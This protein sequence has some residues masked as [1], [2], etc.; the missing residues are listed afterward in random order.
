MPPDS[1]RNHVRFTGILCQIL[2]GI[3]TLNSTP[4]LLLAL[5]LNQSNGIAHGYFFRL[6]TFGQ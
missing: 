2:L 3:N 4:P 5:F 6:G 1:G